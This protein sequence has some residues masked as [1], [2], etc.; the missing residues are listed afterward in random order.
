MKQAIP[1]IITLLH[2]FSGCVATLFAVQ[3]DLALAAL[4]VCV[5]I[6]LDFFD[7]FAARLLK[8]QSPLGVQLDSL[9]DM[10]T[11]GVVPGV[12]MFQLL[13]MAQPEG[14]TSGFW[15]PGTELP[16]LP[17]AGF[18]ITLGS[19]YRLAG[20]NIDQEQ[21]SFFKGLP[22]PANAL[23]I[24]SLPLI[25]VYHNN[26]LLNTLILNEGFLIGLTLVSTF[27]LNCRI[28]LFALKFKNWSFRDNAVRY[29]FLTGSLVLLLTLQFLAVPVVIL[30][31][32]FMALAA[33]ASKKK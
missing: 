23:L 13:L 12:V 22:T 7:G 6:V 33:G 10:V 30:F 1:H 20:F 29:I 27:L 25:L 16:L 5:G 17:F 18:A 21:T 9:A 2:L 4:F 14:A 3:N 26:Q 15:T 8:V 24:V 11:S 31:Y 28:K 19:A 32:I